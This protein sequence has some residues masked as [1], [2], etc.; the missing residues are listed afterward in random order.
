MH[1]IIVI[2]I[3]RITDN[4]KLKAFVDIAVGEITI[5]GVRLMFDPAGGGYWPGLP[6]QP[7]KDKS[8]NQKFAPI[9]EV[10]EGLKKQ[11]KE[12]IVKEYN[13]N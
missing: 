13:Q 6:Q 10:S 8:G 11:I 3:K 2:R 7:Y 12:A 9:V 5:N 4:E 1:P